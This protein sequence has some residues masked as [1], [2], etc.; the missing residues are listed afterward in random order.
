MK[1]VSTW[2]FYN[3]KCTSKKEV[4]CENRTRPVKMTKLLHQTCSRFDIISY[5]F[6]L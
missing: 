2:T 6:K 4:Q 3:N 5:L 1:Q